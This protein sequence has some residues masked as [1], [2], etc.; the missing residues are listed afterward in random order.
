MVA[1][2]SGWPSRTLLQRRGD[3]LVDLVAERCRQS[4]RQRR[5]TNV[6]IERRVQEHI[7]QLEIW[8]PV[9][10]DRM[11][12]NVSVSI[13]WPRRNTAWLNSS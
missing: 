1:R 13:E 12:L 7:Q 2:S 8:S 10:W 3:E 9:I 4:V 6:L 5:R 11:T